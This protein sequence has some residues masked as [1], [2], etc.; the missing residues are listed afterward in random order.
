LVYRTEGE[1]NANSG[2]REGA[3][4]VFLGKTWKLKKYG[5]TLNM[6]AA[7]V[8]GVPSLA[9]QTIVVRIEADPE[10]AKQILEKIDWEALKKL[11]K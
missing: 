8:K 3:T 9:V 10:R 1:F 5:S 11:I 7:A 6:D 4:Y 2:W